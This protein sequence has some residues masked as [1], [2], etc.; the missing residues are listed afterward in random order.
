VGNNDS[1][2]DV[3]PCWAA[4]S[5]SWD[6]REASIAV[7]LEIGDVGPLNEN[8]SCGADREQSPCCKSAQQKTIVDIANV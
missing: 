7:D 5:S 4:L 1:I 3:V 6:S 8:H 2:E